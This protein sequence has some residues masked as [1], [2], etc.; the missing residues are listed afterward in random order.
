[1]KNKVMLLYP[2]G[3]LY[4]RSEDRAQCNISESATGAVHACNDLGYCAAVLLNKGYEVLLRDYQTEGAS[5]KDVVRDVKAFAPD[6]IALSTTNSSVPDDLAFLHRI[7]RLHP[8]ICVVKGAVFY[9]MEPELLNQLDLAAVSCLIGCEMEFVIGALADC[10][11]R[12][13]G[14][15]A[16][17]AS[18]IYKEGEHFVKNEFLCGQNDLDAL[19]FPARQLMKNEL[20]VRPDTGEPMATI[21]TGLGCPSRCIYCLTPL[22][23]G[24]KVR[25]RDVENI[26]KEIEECYTKYGIKN[27]FFKADTFTIDEAYATAVCNRIIRSPL[28]GKIAFTVNSRV[29]PLSRALL[30][31]LKQAGCFMI[32]VGFES[33]NNETLKRIQ[34]GTTVADN[35]RAAKLI[36]EAGIPLFGFFM[37]GFPW[38]DK[39][40]ILQTERF[41]RK[42]NPDFIELHIAMPYYKTGLYELCKKYGVLADSGFGH[43]YY[44]PNTTGTKYLSAAQ[45]QQLKRRILLG[46]YLRPE[47]VFKKMGAAVK[48]PKVIGSYMRY[49]FS[50]LNKNLFRKQ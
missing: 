24:T 36:K 43:D 9:D 19:P 12:G 4:Q 28:C 1:M 41:I 38:E 35:L 20:Y 49:G 39:R 33:G 11:L 13:E 23:S 50:L 14:A 10:Y 47:Y 45:V 15:L 32:A 40:K 21:Q 44:T 27:F 16:D 46:F 34:K 30:A 8:C 37:I 17:I 25:K 22:I 5:M 2:P 29:K 42:I 7:C 3:K 26:Y 18:I 48:Q 6:M 31:K